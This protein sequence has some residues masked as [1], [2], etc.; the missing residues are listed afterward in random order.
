MRVLKLV[1]FLCLTAMI[2]AFGLYTVYT[3]L[4]RFGE[5]ELILPEPV[6]VEL[7]PQMP[8]SLLARELE[9]CG[10]T[11]SAR[12]FELWVRFRSEYSRFQA[13]LYK[14]E[15]SVSALSI[16]EAMIAGRI[17][18][19]VVLE[20]VIPEGFNM[21]AT[22]DRLAAKGLGGREEI[23]SL[24]SD[25]EFLSSLR[26]PSTT[27]EGYLYP[28]TYQFSV[29]PTAAEVL[30]KMV[31][32]F[33]SKLPKDYEMKV[34]ELG[35]SLAQ[36]VTFASLI[37]LETAVEEERPLV[38]EVIWNRLRARAALGIDASIIYGIADYRGNLS[39]AHL[40]DA[41]NP[42]NSRVHL[43]FPPTPIGSPSM[44]SLLAVLSPSRE[45]YYYY[46]LDPSQQ[47]R[48]YFSKSLKEHNEQV[49]RLV[50][51]QVSKR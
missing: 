45:G 40:S 51:A 46:V 24:M 2:V 4:C 34:Q 33:W 43:G 1:L 16:S 8:L 14:F 21:F 13:G 25:K 32:T 22:A 38:S 10:L 31:E 6:I 47:G 15:T 19:P 28:A 17:Y 5:R 30:T 29:M 44:A 41:S 39:K 50:R 36:A 37:E 12:L 18:I 7:K 49:R 42:Y 26:V 20:V 27:I 35:L 9:R 11:D 3:G 23:I 48:H